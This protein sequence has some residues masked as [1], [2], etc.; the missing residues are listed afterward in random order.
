M[1]RACGSQIL[2]GMLSLCDSPELFG[3]CAPRPLLLQLGTND[4]L[5][6]EI[7]AVSL[8]RELRRIF[9]AAGA[10]S[11]PAVAPSAGPV[12]CRPPASP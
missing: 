10:P 5:C 3:L 9:E 4:F 8:D 2:P 1:N 12:C 7:Y 11:R 6:P